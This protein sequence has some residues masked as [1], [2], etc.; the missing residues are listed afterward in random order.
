MKRQRRASDDIE[1]ECSRDSLAFEILS[2]KFPHVGKA[3]IRDV[4]HGCAYDEDLAES[5]L[6]QVYGAA[7]RQ[8]LDELN[9]YQNVVGHHWQTTKKWEEYKPVVKRVEKATFGEALPLAGDLLDMLREQQEQSSHESAGE[10]PV[11][12]QIE[13]IQE[14]EQNDPNAPRDVDK[15]AAML[16]EVFPQLEAKQ[17]Q[18]TV[19][20][21]ASI[22]LAYG[23]LNECV[24]DGHYDT[25]KHKWC[26]PAINSWNSKKTGWDDSD[27]E[28]K[29]DDRETGRETLESIAQQIEATPMPDEDEEEEK[30]EEAK[31][32]TNDEIIEMYLDFIDEKGGDRKQGKS[33]ED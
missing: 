30:E 2:N 10:A 20:A 25:I 12:E 11:E 6:S 21:V 8:K 32:L 23:Y 29:D 27:E 17:V 7:K 18:N 14:E 24:E 16:K 22:D 33:L 26:F 5:N 19:K 9:P 13:M 3:E 4:L 31:E 15:E 28:Q 1:I